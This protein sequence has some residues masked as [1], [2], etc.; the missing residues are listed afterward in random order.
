[1]ST[2]LEEILKKLGW[3]D[4]FQIPVANAENQ[5]LEEEVARLTLQ[6]LKAKT[7]FETSTVKLEN[8]EHHIKYISTESEQTQNLITVH[9]QQ[10][11]ADEHRLKTH[12]AQKNKYDHDIRECEKKTAEIKE[13][14]KAKR[15]Q[16]E[17]CAKKLNTLKSE[18]EWDT[19]ALKAWE[20]SLQKRDDDNELI[21]KFSKQDYRKYNELEAKRQN[22]ELEF[23]SRKQTI[24]KMVCDLTNYE[25]MLERTGKIMKQQ[26]E[27]RNALIQQW[28]DSVKILQQRDNDIDHTQT[29]IL[30]TQEII[31]KEQEKL[32]EHKQFHENELKNNND[33]E[34]EKQQLNYLNSKLRRELHE[35]S[36]YT[37]LLHSQA[38]TV[39]RQMVHIAHQLEKERKNKKTIHEKIA[40]TQDK[41]EN[42]KIR[43]NALREKNEAIKKSAMSADERTRQLEKLIDYEQK[44]QNALQSDCELLQNIFFRVQQELQEQFSIG[45]MRDLDINGVVN[46]INHLRKHNDDQRKALGKRKEDAYEL[47]YKI[48]EVQRKILIKENVIHNE[49]TEELEIK[50]LELENT[51]GERAE[52]KNMLKDQVN[53]IRDD[54]RRLTS[55]IVADQSQLVVLKDKM[56]H[57][58]LSYEGGQK[59]LQ[60]L[61]ASIQEKQVE[62]NILRLR[63]NQLN[64]AM[65]KEEK[66]IYSMKKFKLTLEQATQERLIEIS[67]NKDILLVKRR[68][69]SEDKGRLKCDIAER[70]IKLE[71]F[72]KKYDITL[73]TM[74]KDEDGQTL[75]ITHFKI[76]NAQE[77]FLLQ[78]EG[79][80]LDIKIKTAEKEIL[81]MENTLKVVNLTNA[82]F[83]QSL[84]AVEEEGTEIQ[85]MKVLENQLLMVNDVLRANRKKLAEKRQEV[86]EVKAMLKDLE[87]RITQDREKQVDLEEEY[88]K[89]QREKAQKEEKVKRAENCLKQVEK[90]LHRKQ[91]EK[92]DRDLEIRQLYNA[93]LN[94]MHRLV[95]MSIRYQ[96]VAPLITRY[97]IEYEIKLPEKRTLSGHTESTRSIQTCSSTES[98]TKSVS[99]TDSGSQVSSIA[100][101]VITFKA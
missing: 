87:I 96:E 18:T 77:K 50:L 34:H 6:K 62:E 27:E 10:L 32:Q 59:Q 39:R 100:K 5:Q 98:E 19:E 56:Q 78:Q 99:D 21:K 83:K 97:T 60:T 65:K 3:E 1:M 41:I 82:A 93:N 57:Q 89:V 40:N 33:L 94:A 55:A 64:K 52:I 25:R 69:L 72:Q 4:G 90:K 91:R 9:A 22:L 17:R 58:N 36:Q 38:D 20:E 73:M 29:Q 8:I 16:L 28:K 61:K 54:M 13:R 35:L 71:Q 48:D 53:K 84:S 76:K 31:E 85:E 75:S 101:V 92:Y 2:Y 7:Q 70:R 23:A 86:E 11:Q 80:E 63:V 45:K 88:L 12:E 14:Q 47:D 81:A 74:G 49:F 66:S 43:A 37:L 79:D 68:N 44:Q 67:T 95:E 42:I 51:M 26:V 15:A 24:Q 30:E 46:N